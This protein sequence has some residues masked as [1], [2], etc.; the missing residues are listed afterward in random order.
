MDVRLVYKKT[1]KC[2]AFR[3]DSIFGLTPLLVNCN[4]KRISKLVCRLIYNVHLLGQTK[5][6]KV[7]LRRH[8]AYVFN[9]NT[10]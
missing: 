9:K 5:T 2:Q 4:I 7:K 8:L 1:P 6:F 10:S 3:R